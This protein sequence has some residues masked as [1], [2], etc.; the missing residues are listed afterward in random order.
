MTG[1][2][3]DGLARRCAEDARDPPEHCLEL[4]P[5]DDEDLTRRE[6]IGRLWHAR[7]MLVGTR[8]LCVFVVVGAALGAHFGAMDAPP[9]WRWL[10]RAVCVAVALAA[11]VAAIRVRRRPEVIVPGAWALVML[12][13]GLAG[14]SL[15]R[16]GLL[17]VLTTLL[18]C[19]GALP[20]WFNLRELM[21]RGKHLAAEHPQLQAARAWRGE[22][23]VRDP[24]RP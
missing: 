14:A 15:L 21:F 18:A 1:P 23:A 22:P 2:A 13:G 16:D 7:D 6:V 9:Q 4:E 10:V 11:L 24:Y 17:S 8:W 19:V 3:R 20:T 12:A 5:Q